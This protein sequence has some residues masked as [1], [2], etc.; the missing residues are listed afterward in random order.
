LYYNIVLYNLN[1]SEGFNFSVYKK[2]YFLKI[3]DHVKKKKPFYGVDSPLS[4]E[5]FLVSNG[6]RMEEQ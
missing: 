2:G 4:P 3:V 6:V 5:E 1:D